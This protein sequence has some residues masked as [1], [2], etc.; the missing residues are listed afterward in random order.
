M[1]CALHVVCSQL[2]EPDPDIVD[3]ISKKLSEEQMEEIY[4]KYERIRVYY[5]ICVL[6]RLYSVIYIY[7][8]ESP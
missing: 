6:Y 8:R 2:P 7:T 3:G 1:Q 4:K 5:I